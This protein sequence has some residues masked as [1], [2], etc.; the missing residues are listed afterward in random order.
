MSNLLQE[1]RSTYDHIILDLPPVA[2]IVDART[3]TQ[4]ADLTV[5]VVECGKTKVGIVD[6]ALKQ[7]NLS[8]EQI[9][10]IALN[11]FDMPML[12]RLERFGG[13][14]YTNSEYYSRYGYTD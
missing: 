11:K 6:V 1:L 4:L 10:G 3:A 12:T 8:E 7:L 9:L 13:K 5:M 2:P 14:Y